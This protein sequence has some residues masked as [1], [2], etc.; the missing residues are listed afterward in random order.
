MYDPSQ[1][2]LVAETLLKKRRSLE[3]LAIVRSE[4]VQKQVKRRR[5]VRGETIRVVRPE[6]LV[7]IHRIKNGSEK[8]LMRQ[9]KQAE[10]K[11]NRMIKNGVSFQSTVGFIV[12]VRDA[13]SASKQIKKELNNLGLNKI[14]NGVFHKLDAESI[15]KSLF[16]FASV[17]FSVLISLPFLP[18]LAQLKPLESY[19][20]YG[21]I[22]LKSVEELIHRR[23]YTIVEGTKKPLNSNL[24]IE[25]VLGNKNI[26]CVNDLT[27]E[28]YNVG[29][30]FKDSLEVL[31]SFDLSA[32][33][34][35]YEKKILHVFN[36]EHGFLGENMEDFLKKL[37]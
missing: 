14:Y 2:P 37:L 33:I 15:G 29:E 20:A 4:T 12:R 27:H 30:H 11:V 18:S 22:S 31:S 16:Y 7:K 32:P 19:I 34:G 21:Y 8:R 28:I 10:F 5:V 35:N 9:K 13:K 24:I 25:E 26:L 3:E 17:F 36:D 23:A 1:T 6:Q